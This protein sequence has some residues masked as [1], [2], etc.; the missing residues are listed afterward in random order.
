MKDL[1]EADV[2][3]NIKLN[4]GENGITLLQSHYVEKVLNRFGYMDCKPSP[5]PYDPSLILRKNKRLGKDHLRYSQIIG[6]LMYLASAT[7]PDISFAVSKLSRFSSNPGSDHWRGIDRVMRYLKGTM[8][9]AIHYSGY[10]GVLEG[11]SDSN[12]ISEADE[13][14]AT[15]GYIFTLGGGAVS[16]RSCKQTIL[17]KSTMEAE[18]TALDTASTEA[19]WLRD[20]LMDLPLV[21]KPIPAILINCDNQTVITKVKNSQD[22][23]KKSSKHI[24]RRLKSV[25]KLRSS[26]V[27]A[28]DYIQTAK[29]LADPFTKGLSRTVIDNASK[30]MGLRPM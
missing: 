16:W 21:E 28:V 14:K 8:S 18:L 19:E 4:K 7:R 3:L 6:S 26:G 23:G 20:M 12:W 30:E 15:S 9:Y 1:G 25:R 24:K 11:Y 27:I 17:T 2:I 5:T 13:L 29:N 10:P 22:N